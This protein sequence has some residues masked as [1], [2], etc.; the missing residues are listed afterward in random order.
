[1]SRQRLLIEPA[2]HVLSTVTQE[3]AVDQNARQDDLTLSYIQHE[4][5]EKRSTTKKAIRDNPSNAPVGKRLPAS[6]HGST[7]NTKRKQLDAMAVVTRMGPPD[8]MV[9]FTANSNWPE[10]T[11]NLLPGQTGMD[12]PDLVNR[13]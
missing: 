10:I 2:F 12:R 8:L 1:Y 9:T 7:I 11:A 6:F 5:P 13:V 4:L 3:F